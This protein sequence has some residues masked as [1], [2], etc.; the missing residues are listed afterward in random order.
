MPDA[1]KTTRIATKIV[2]G[3]KR[4]AVST[5]AREE[6]GTLVAKCLRLG[7]SELIFQRITHDQENSNG[8]FF[9]DFNEQLPENIFVQLA[10]L[11]EAVG[12]D[13][14]ASKM[15]TNSIEYLEEKDEKEEESSW[16]RA[17]LCALP[18]L[19]R[20][21]REGK[22]DNNNL[23]IRAIKAS[24]SIALVEEGQASSLASLG[25]L[26]SLGLERGIPLEN[27]LCEKIVVILISN[28]TNARRQY[29]YEDRCSAILGASA[30]L[31]GSSLSWCW[32]PPPPKQSATCKYSSSS[33]V[34]DANYFVRPLLFGRGQDLAKK[35]L[36]ALES[37]SSSSGGGVKVGQLVKL[38]RWRWDSLLFQRERS[39]S[40]GD[41]S[42]Q[43]KRWR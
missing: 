4:D 6:I 8:A 40:A 9:N 34:D 21:L 13:E 16:R 27:A 26:A 43:Q 12:D 25:A 10:S 7:C 22:D 38:H 2:N 37:I 39:Y 20:V 11:I 14:L 31:A 18:I 30:L 3:F 5:R 15:V 23:I 36:K 42:K 28:A 17:L 19:A 29:S 1:I 41:V 24:L 33:L 32:L 35:L